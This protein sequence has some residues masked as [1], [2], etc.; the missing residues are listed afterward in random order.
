MER[1]IPWCQ[2]R[3]S[4][5]QAFIRINKILGVGLPSGKVRVSHIS[6]AP[7]IIHNALSYLLEGTT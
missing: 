2:V 4:K 1:R 5:L 6:I 3:F 7:D